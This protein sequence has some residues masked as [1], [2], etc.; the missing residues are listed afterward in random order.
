MPAVVKPCSGAGAEILGVSLNNLSE[1]D[2]STIKSELSKRGVVF[3]RDQTLS[4]EEHV[5]FAK[6]FGPINVN[7]F[8]KKVDGHPEVA[9]VLKDKGDIINLGSVF[10]T[11]T[12]YDVDPCLGSVLV[13]RELPEVGGDTLFVDMYRAFE[14]LPE[15]LKLKVLGMN[16]VHSS[17]HVFG[18]ISLLDGDRLGNGEQASQDAVHPVVLTHPDSGRKV[19]FVNPTFTIRFEGMTVEESWPLLETLYRHAAQ[20]QQLHRFHWLPGSV[21]FWDNRATWHAALNDYPGCRRLMHRVTIEGR[22]LTDLNT[23]Q[24]AA[25]AGSIQGNQYNPFEEFHLELVQRAIET[26]TP[27]KL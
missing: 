5:N 11:D 10:H 27:S 9:E 17:R 2:L 12:S 23:P 18:N 15:D 16:A 7:R 20:P 22:Q 24:R 21:A 3:F 1:E 8:F 14:T 26:T 19:L 13:A 4:P 6:L 25:E